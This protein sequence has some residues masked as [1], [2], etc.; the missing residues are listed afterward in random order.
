MIELDTRKLCEEN[1]ILYKINRNKLQGPI[2]IIV[3]SVEHM[4]LGHYIYKY[5]IDNN[6]YSFFNK[7]IGRTLFKTEEEAI[8]ELEKLKKCSI[9]RRLMKKYEKKL[10]KELDI[11]NHIIVR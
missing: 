1:D 5:T 7:A 9:K 3:K 11:D 8:K 4:D 2:E 10:N 6:S